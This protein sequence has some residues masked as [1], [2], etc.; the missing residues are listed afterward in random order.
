MMKQLKAQIKIEALA[1][2][3]Q[4]VPLVKIAKTLRQHRVTIARWRDKYGWKIHK[5]IEE[6]KIRL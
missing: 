4:G 3:L 5:K 2:Y 6:G 1:M